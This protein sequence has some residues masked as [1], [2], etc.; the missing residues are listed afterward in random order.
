MKVMISQP[1]YLPHPM[2][3]KRI[4]EADLLVLMDD[5]QR[6][7]RGYENRNLMRVSP[8]KDAW[9]TVPVISSNRCLIK[10][11]VVGGYVTDHFRKVRDWYG[12]KGWPKPLSAHFGEPQ[13]PMYMDELK[14]R[15]TAAMNY[16]GI[17]TPVVIQSSLGHF[18]TKGK[19]LIVEIAKKVGADTYLSGISC[20]D[21]GLDERFMQEH[22]ITL[23]IDKYGGE[24]EDGAGAMYGWLHYELTGAS[25]RVAA[26]LR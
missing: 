9:L 8:D 22:G 4:K 5:T 1:R 10:D 6:V 13:L 26:Y 21:Y 16:Y 23:E 7:Q 2:Y 15:L 14:Q 11:A 19:E 3:L 18:S 12:V 20:Y 25:N 24:I 17:D